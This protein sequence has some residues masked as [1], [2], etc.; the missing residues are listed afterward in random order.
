MYREVPEVTGIFIGKLN[1]TLFMYLLLD[2]SYE[3][4]LSDTKKYITPQNLL[5]ANKLHSDL[6]EVRMTLS[7]HYFPGIL[8]KTDKKNRLAYP[9][10]S[11]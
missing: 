10:T 8:F 3:I 11:Y 2:T 6:K 9:Y 1:M 4:L 7:W 5:Q